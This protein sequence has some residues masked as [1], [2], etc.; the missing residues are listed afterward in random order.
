[1]SLDMA[2]RHDEPPHLMVGNLNRDLLD[3]SVLQAWAKRQEV[4]LKAS[5]MTWQEW[6]EKNGISDWSRKKLRVGGKISYMFADAFLTPAGMM[7][8]DLYGWPK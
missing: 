5:G 4:R 2:A 3:A 6:C 8:E 1:M 7:P